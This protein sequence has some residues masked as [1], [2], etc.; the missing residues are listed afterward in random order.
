MTTQNLLT[1]YKVLLRSC[2]D[3]LAP[4]YHSLLT[5]QQSETLEKLQQTALGIIYG[6]RLNY[7]EQLKKAGRLE[8]LKTRRLE[9]TRK[10]AE[11]KARNERFAHFFP[12]HRPARE[13][14]R[15][16]NTYLEENAKTDRLY[17]SPIFLWDDYWIR[18][19]TGPPSGQCLPACPIVWC[20][21]CFYLLLLITGRTLVPLK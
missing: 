14:A 15:K 20:L 12:P 6:F 3:Y 4:A 21:F 19:M 16:K 1:V 8:T 11:K 18:T 5:G 9:L 10:F 7:G 2:L 17:K 13:N